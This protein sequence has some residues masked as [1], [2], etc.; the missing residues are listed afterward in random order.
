M[1]FKCSLA[2]KIFATAIFLVGSSNV[3]ALNFTPSEFEWQTW[4]EKCQARYV[5][6]GRGSKSIFVHRVSKAVVNQWNKK[7]G[8]TAWYML[9]HYCA[10]IIYERRGKIAEGIKEYEYTIAT[11]PANFDFHADI[12]AR[13]A[14][15]HYKLKHLDKALYYAKQAIDAKPNLPN[16]YVVKAF[17]ERNE[18][19]IDEAIKTLVEGNINTQKRDSEIN[20]HLGLAYMKR[21]QY[22]DAM[23]Y[24]KAAYKLGYPLP[25]LKDQLTKVG[26]W[27]ED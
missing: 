4:G 20:Y 5:V 26:V 6:S 7:V 18:G 11:V 1:K 8:R 16:G 17:I 9:H 24:A 13:M 12:A 19:S 2:I 22:Q 27:T 21:E 3:Y 14:R 23:T 10:G 15:A 25:G